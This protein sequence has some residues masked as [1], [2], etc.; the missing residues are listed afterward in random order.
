[1]FCASLGAA[2]RVA[3]LA[4]SLTHE[5]S[6]SE[7]AGGGDASGM[8]GI[9]TAC[10]WRAPASSCEA[11]GSPASIEGTGSAAAQLGDAEDL[12]ARSGRLEN[13]WLLTRHQTVA[14]G[15]NAR[16]LRQGTRRLFRMRAA[17]LALPS[18][19]LGTLRGRSI[20]ALGRGSADAAEITEP[21]SSSDGAVTAEPPL[22]LQGSPAASC[23]SFAGCTR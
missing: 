13:S 14:A 18:A 11:G 5:A 15:R 16:R 21:S 8:P 1:M 22:D 4:L 19:V 23:T 3:S 20:L 10:G 9:P 7:E 17:G 12:A 2:G 6:A